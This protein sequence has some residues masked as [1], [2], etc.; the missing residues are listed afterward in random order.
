MLEFLIRGF[1]FGDVINGIFYANVRVPEVM[2]R[3]T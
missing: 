2:N 1:L 3:N